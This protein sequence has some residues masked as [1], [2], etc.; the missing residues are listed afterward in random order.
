MVSAA[1]ALD[2]LQEAFTRMT[3]PPADT[4]LISTSFPSLARIMAANHADIHHQ[5]PCETRVARVLSHF[6]NASVQCVEPS[7]TTQPIVV[8][9]EEENVTLADR[10]GS[11]EEGDDMEYRG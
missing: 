1:Q 4:A 2:V 5:V 8:D 6:F 3:V 7:A 9:D 11:W 10:D